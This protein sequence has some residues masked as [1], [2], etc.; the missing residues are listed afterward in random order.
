LRVTGGYLQEPRNESHPWDPALRQRVR[1]CQ[2]DREVFELLLELRDDT[3]YI[4]YAEHSLDLVFHRRLQQARLFVDRHLV[5]RNHRQEIAYDHGT[6][7]TNRRRSPTNL[8]VYHNRPSESCDQPCVHIDARITGH[9]AMT[10]ADLA[11]FADWLKLDER[12]F[13]RERLYLCGVDLSRLGRLLHNKETGRH[14]RGGWEY[15]R[16]TGFQAFARVHRSVQKLIDTYRRNRRA[17]LPDRIRQ[18]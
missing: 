17:F 4:N 9:A 16:L 5:K 18:H 11:T 8:V 13:W 2:P 15:D 10:R 14:R 12:E 7:Y 3:P 6:L 1:I